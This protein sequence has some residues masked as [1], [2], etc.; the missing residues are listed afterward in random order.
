MG[1]LTEMG[2]HYF[3]EFPKIRRSLIMSKKIE[4]TKTALDET[5]KKGCG[6]VKRVL[7]NL[8]PDYEFEKE[9]ESNTIYKRDGEFYRLTCFQSGK[10]WSLICLDGSSLYGGSPSWNGINS[11]RDI[12]ETI[13]VEGF[14]LCPNATIVVKE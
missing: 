1:I 10:T 9:I 4:I 12:K 8:F 2:E 3:Q 14:I 11:Q 6:D 7:K 13:D 5:Y